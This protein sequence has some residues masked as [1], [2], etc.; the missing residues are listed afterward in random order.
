ME[1]MLCAALSLAVPAWQDLF[2]GKSLSDFVIRGGSGT[3]RLDKGELVGTAHPGGDNTFLCTRQMYGD[4]ELT[5]DALNANGLNSGVQIRGNSNKG[6]QNGRVNGYQVEMDPSRRAFS[7]GIYDE[8]RRGIYLQDPNVF[9]Q[10]RKAFKPGEWNHFRVK[11]VG[12]HIETWVNGIKTADLW[13]NVT[14]QGFFAF[15]VHAIGNDQ[16]LRDVHFKNVK[17]LDLG[18]PSQKVPTKAKWLLRSQKDLLTNWQAADGKPPRWTWEGDHAVTNGTGSISTKIAPGS[19]HLHAEFMTSDNGK[20]GQA[21]GNSGIFL[22]GSYEVQILNSFPR[23]PM[24]DECGSIYSI[25]AP[26]YA[27]AEPA[28]VWQ[29]YDIWYWEPLWKGKEKVGNARMSVYLNGTL[30]Q[31]YV[32]LTRT[33][34]G[35]PEHSDRQPIA[36][37]D[38]GNP[39]KFRNIWMETL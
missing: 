31:N 35:T 19:V 34:N 9:P 39:I 7:G 20:D 16:N 36:L 26:D 3:Y 38:H 29:T 11:A 30:V 10:A 17:V 23:G 6:Y 37:Q 8:G 24:I 2:A 14:Q 4:F 15:Q 18:I 28:G 27:M 1:G 21:N 13:D 33:T 22:D 5:Y 32:E 12:S 25:K